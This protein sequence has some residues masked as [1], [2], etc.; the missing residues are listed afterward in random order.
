MGYLYNDGSN[1]LSYQTAI[2]QIIPGSANTVLLSGGSNNIT[3]GTGLTYNGSLLSVAG[4]VSASGNVTASG[5]V[6]ASNISGTLTTAS[7]TNITAV[8]ILTGLQINGATIANGAFNTGNASVSNLAASGNVSAAGQIISSIATG[9]APLVVTSTTTV[10]NLHVAVAG[11]AGTVTSAAQPNITSLGTL[12]SLSVSGNAN[13][14]NIGATGGYFTAIVQGGTFNGSGSGLTSLNA[15]NITSGTISS[16]YVPT[17]NQNTTGYAATVSS[18]AQPNIT[19][20]GTLTSL[21]VSGNANI[22]NVG[23]AGQLVS[24]V[25]TGTAPIVVTSTT[26]VANLNV[27]T[28]G[29]AGTVTSAAQPNI[30]SVGTLSS[31]SASGDITAANLHA[32]SGTV[33]AG[34]LYTP[35][36][37]NGANV[38]ATSYHIRSVATGISAAGSTQGGATALTKEINIVSTVSSGQGVALP[39]AVAGMIVTV[40]NTTGTALL[41]YPASGAAINSLSTNAAFSQGTTTI[42][43]IAPTTTQWYTTGATY[44]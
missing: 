12:S 4:D 29:V 17:L 13:V 32:N 22:G 27:A 18:A 44:A 30:T 41:V 34:S 9:T 2:T 37:I 7:Q 6:V 40:T 8:G 28:A 3:A 43:F 26:Q 42:Q 10:A 25:A 21:S 20:V 16:S 39:A 15:S 31:L 14:G 33:T 11:N 1:N 35:G 38:I 19:S 36:N 5:N 24:T 23:T